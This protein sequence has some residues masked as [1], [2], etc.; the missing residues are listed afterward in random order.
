MMRQRWRWQGVGVV[1]ALVGIGLGGCGETAPPPA[2]SD[3]G[4]LYVDL[5]EAIAAGWESEV[6]IFGPVQ[7]GR[8]CHGGEC[9][10]DHRRLEIRE[11][12]SSDE[13]VVEVLSVEEESFLGVPAIRLI[14]EGKAEGEAGIELVFDVEG[15]DPADFVEEAQEEGGEFDEV[16]AD[17]FRDSFRV[18]VREVAEIRL[19]RYLD[20]VDPSGPYGRCPAEGLGVYLTASPGEY[21]VLVEAVKLDREG[22]RLRGGG[23]LPFTVDPEG[24]MEVIEVIES[25]HLYRL[26]PQEYGALR[27]V[28]REESEGGELIFEVR[29]PSQIEEIDMRGF[30][31]SQQGSRVREVTQFQVGS[32]YEIVAQARIEGGPLCGGRLETQVLSLTPGICEGAGFVQGRGTAA[33]YAHAA[34]ECLLRVQAPGALG[35]EGITRD[36]VIPVAHV[37]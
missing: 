11:V 29:A 4:H 32:Y 9:Y 12:L 14:L 10:F 6:L 1:L 15:L 21:D 16:S 34:G 35:G 33:F 31:L 23:D 19:Q 26:R 18:K 22:G 30:E 2:N 37:F 24:A 3:Q 25:L 17:H 28:P 13:A 7:G 8:R 5:E 36:L 20:H 27:V